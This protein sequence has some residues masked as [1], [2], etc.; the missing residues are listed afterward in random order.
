MSSPAPEP[1]CGV[2]VFDLVG[3]QL[4]DREKHLLRHPAMAGLILFTRNFESR[5]Q[6]TDLVAQV[7]DINND[8]LIMADQEGGRVQRF[9]G[10]G[11]TTVPS[12][13]TFGRL[14]RNSPAQAVELIKDTGWL[15]GSELRSVGIDLGLSPVLD[16]DRGISRVIGDRGFSDNPDIVIDLASA[17]IQG[18]HA[19]GMKSVGKHFPGHGGIGVD[20]HIALPTDKRTL[21]EIEPDLRPYMAL[22]QQGLDGVMPAHVRFPELDDAPA[23]FSR[24]WL[25]D[26]LR[27]KVDF[28]GAVFSDCLCMAGASVAGDIVQ[29]SIKALDAGCDAILACNNPDAVDQVVQAWE[30]EK[31][32]AVNT[33]QRKR[34]EA[35]K[36]SS[37]VLWGDLESDPRRV[38]TQA[39]LKSLT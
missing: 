14:W 25:N 10:E 33:L 34:L 29:R 8:L 11:F 1:R 6:L 7:R 37:S 3:Q 4:T 30:Q 9:R 17:F 26:M 13:G 15:L 32:P 16:L 19:A 22:T 2:L 24:F 31:L 35:M 20:S 18:L 36:G 21:C 23:G 38:E 28:N 5:A 27:E 39:R 12:M